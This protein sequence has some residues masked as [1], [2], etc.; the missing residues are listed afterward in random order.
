MFQRTALVLAVCGILTLLPG[1]TKGESPPP[2]EPAGPPQTILFTYKPPAG[3][4]LPEVDTEDAAALPRY[5]TSHAQ[6]ANRHFAANLYRKLAEEN[7]EANLFFS[8]YSISR[9]L[10]MSA[11]G[12]R[13]ETALQ[14]GTVLGFHPSLRNKKEDAKI[15]PWDLTLQH[16]GMATIDRRLSGDNVSPKDHEKLE[17]IAKLRHKHQAIKDWF[18]KVAARDGKYHS[19]GSRDPQRK[20]LERVAGIE[21]SLIRELDGLREKIDTH[22]LRIANSIWLEKTHP[23]ADD[24]V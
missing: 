20:E 5:P 19:Y 17:Q 21:R 8:P 13:G 12:A 3:P 18:A 10:V 9:A 14:M 11:E 6:S 1:D 2:S 7:P 4:L 22:E 24:F 23:F 15:D 16:Q